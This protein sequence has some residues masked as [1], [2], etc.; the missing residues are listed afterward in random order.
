MQCYLLQQG[1]LK[2]HVLWVCSRLLILF[3]S[4]FH[5]RLAGRTLTGRRHS[6]PNWRNCWRV[7]AKAMLPVW[8]PIFFRCWVAFP[9]KRPV[10]LQSSFPECW[11]TLSKGTGSFFPWLSVFLSDTVSK[12]M[13][14]GAAQSLQP[15]TTSENRFPFNQTDCAAHFLLGSNNRNVT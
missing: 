8:L 14:Y 13:V 7:V 9:W 12:D 11:T 1:T 4:F 3:F 5:C 6:G 15:T 10:E 2:I